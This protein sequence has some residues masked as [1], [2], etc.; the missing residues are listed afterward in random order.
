MKKQLLITI[1]TATM[2]FAGPNCGKSHDEASA[3]ATAESH[4]GHDHGTDETHTAQQS[5][6][7]LGEKIDHHFF[8]DHDGERL[9]ACSEK[10]K[11][12]IAKEFDTYK[13]MLEDLGEEVG[14]AE[15][16][17]ETHDEHDAKGS[18]SGHSH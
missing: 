1:A 10:C 7:V 11:K 17:D 12:E 4:E 9:Y 2:L 6:P 3:K 14:K 16:H 8:V 5:C 18:C 15:A 13:G